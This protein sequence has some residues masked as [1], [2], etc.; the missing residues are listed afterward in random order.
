MIAAVD[1]A[2]RRWPEFV[3][4]LQNR[5]APDEIFA[6][7]ARFTEGEEEEFMWVSVDRIDGERILGRLENSPAMIK[8]LREGDL[9]TVPRENLNDW[10]YS[11]GGEPVGGFTMKVME[12]IMKK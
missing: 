3:A 12:E 2:N 10:L 7:K 4:A 9:V 11:S 6:V 8:S 1:E 5:K